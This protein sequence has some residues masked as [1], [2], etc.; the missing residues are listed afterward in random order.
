M[1]ADMVMEELRVL[2]LD[3]QAAE[4]VCHSGH[5]LSIFVGRPCW[6]EVAVY[7][8]L[9]T[10]SVLG[11]MQGRAQVN[12]SNSLSDLF[13]R[14]SLGLVHHLSQVWPL[15]QFPAKATP[16]PLPASNMLIRHCA[17]SL[18]VGPCCYI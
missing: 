18:T 1:Q 16:P 15:T 2:P 12:S 6:F 9:A 8:D 4:G 13:W 3:P 11:T 14:K 10:L 17:R 5:V 7:H